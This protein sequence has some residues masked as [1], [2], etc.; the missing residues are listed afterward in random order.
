MNVSEKK[1]FYKGLGVEG[2]IDSGMTCTDETLY[3]HIM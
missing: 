2:D 1:V 3:V